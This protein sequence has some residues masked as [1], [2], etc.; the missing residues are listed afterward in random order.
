MTTNASSLS[1]SE[2]QEFLER[3]LSGILAT[4]L[5]R[6]LVVIS[7]TLSGKVGRAAKSFFNLISSQIHTPQANESALPSQQLIKS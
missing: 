2:T 3:Y 4:G 5:L 1:L 7:Q 6:P